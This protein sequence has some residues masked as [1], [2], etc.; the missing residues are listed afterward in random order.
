METGVYA[1]SRA[2]CKYLSLI[3][4]HAAFPYETK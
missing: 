4:E 3:A 1:P 2:M